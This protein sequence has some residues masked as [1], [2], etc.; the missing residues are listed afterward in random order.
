MSS[1]MNQMRKTPLAR[2]HTTQGGQLQ[3]Q[4]VGHYEAGGGNA[5]C[6]GLTDLTGLA[7]IG[8]KGADT[9]QWLRTMHVETPSA[10]NTAIL[11]AGILT[12]RLSPTE[13]MLVAIDNQPSS[14]IDSL[15]NGWSMDIDERCYLL[16]R[17]HSHACFALTGPSCPEMLA[18]VCAIDLR[19]HKFSALQ[20]AQTSVARS[21][22]IVIRLDKQ[23]QHPQFLIMADISVAEFLWEC[24]LDAMQE[25]LGQALSFP[26]YLERLK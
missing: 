5:Q 9:E 26:T 7:R 15:R 17:G 4:L 21:N 25:F 2:W 23:T 1:S 8:F 11:N 14:L 3:N 22:A 12:A 16:E 6:M 20:V 19:A 18:K 24:L 10:A 13:F